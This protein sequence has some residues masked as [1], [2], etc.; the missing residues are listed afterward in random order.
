MTSRMLYEQY[1]VIFSYFSLL[2]VALYNQHSLLYWSKNYLISECCPL[3]LA[4]ACFDPRNGIISGVLVVGT[5][6]GLDG[7]ADIL[8]YTAASSAILMWVPKG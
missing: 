1:C 3:N 5:V 6:R 8:A 7:P 2:L 4:G